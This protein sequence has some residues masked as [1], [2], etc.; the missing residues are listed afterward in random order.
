MNNQ[1]AMMSGRLQAPTAPKN[2]VGLSGANQI[3][4]NPVI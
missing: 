1:S 3:N 4:N 2:G